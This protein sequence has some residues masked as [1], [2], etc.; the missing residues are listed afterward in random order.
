MK[1]AVMG[2]SGSGKSTL[3]QRISEYY[4]IPAL[5]LDQI[6]FESGWKERDRETARAMVRSFMEGTDWVID[7]NYRSF[8]AEER[9]EAADQ[10]VYLKFSRISCLSRVIRRY[11]RY[12]G[13]VRE[14]MAEG[15]PEKLDRAFIWWV[16]YE[17]RTRKRRAEFKMLLQPYGD[18]LTILKN[19]RQLNA[20]TAALLQTGQAL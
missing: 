16:L 15:C 5:H 13:A 1:I 11:R 19:Q 3:T 18:K 4:R 2:Y 9:L 14:S 20:F 12:K 8:Y 10:I 17:G 7:G 6:Q